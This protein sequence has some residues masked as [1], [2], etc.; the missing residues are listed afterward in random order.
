M[1]LAGRMA[2]V[3]QMVADAV[4]CISSLEQDTF[5]V[6]VCERLDE[7]EASM[8]NGSGGLRRVLPDPPAEIPSGVVDMGGVRSGAS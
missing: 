1:T 6:E 5:I 2:D 4:G 8:A 3:E 7:L